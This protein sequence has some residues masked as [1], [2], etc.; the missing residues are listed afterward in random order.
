MYSEKDYLESIDAIAEESGKEVKKARLVINNYFLPQFEKVTSL[1]KWA[2]DGM[3]AEGDVSEPIST[4]NKIIIAQL[5][6]SIAKGAPEFE[7]AKQM[8]YGAAFKH[9]KAEVYKEKM[10]GG[11]L[12]QIA[13]TVGSNVQT[14]DIKF[15][16]NTIVGGGGNEPK[17]VGIACGLEAGEKTE[18]I[19]GEVG[20]YV[21]EIISVNAAPETSD[22]SAQKQSLTRTRRGLVDGGVFNALRE[23]ADVQDNRRRL[24]YNMD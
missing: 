2:F 13:Q 19:E 14:G 15:S 9:K 20:V 21:I 11:N 22:L 5:D 10:Q 24:E 18:P 4:G 12:E 7:D 1:K 17:V 3:T 23:K 8:M 16:S 6:N